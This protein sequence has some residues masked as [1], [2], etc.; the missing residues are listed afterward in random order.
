MGRAVAQA[1]PI[2]LDVSD[3]AVLIVGGGRVAGRKASG[4]LDAGAM[5]VRA[6]APAFAD[7][8]PK[9]VQRKVKAYDRS[10]L[11]GADLVFA[12]TGA[13]AVND[14]VVADARVRRVWAS[15]AADAGRGDFVTPARFDR[16]PVTVAVSAGSAALAVLLRDGLAQRFDPAWAS[17][18]AAMAELRPWLRD[19]SGLDEPARRAVFRSLATDEACIVL[20]GQGMGGLKRW[21]KAR[22]PSLPVPSP[23]TPGEG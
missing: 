5:R 10:D 16:G 20:A 7:D 6:V 2:F 9:G 14:A 3:R 18:A 17:M 4:L 23:G 22:Y 1:Y 15:H 13:A 12:A 8:F 19:R 21:L 11:D